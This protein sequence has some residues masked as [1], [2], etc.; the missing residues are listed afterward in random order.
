MER[1]QYILLRGRRPGSA[2]FRS[3]VRF[4]FLRNN[5]CLLFVTFLELVDPS[6]GIHQYILARKERMRGVG[7][8]QFDQRIF[9]TVF[10]FDIFAGLGGGTADKAGAIAHILEDDKTI[11][12]GVEAF[13]HFFSV[14]GCTDLAVQLIKLRVQN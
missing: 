13:F 11:I 6:C 5:L 14:L 4:L 9:L 7:N 1:V 12:R 8:F 10:P 2:L 3:G